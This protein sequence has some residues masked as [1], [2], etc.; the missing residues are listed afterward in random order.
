MAP[1]SQIVVP[2][3]LGLSYV[4]VNTPGEEPPPEKGLVDVAVLDMHH[5]YANLGHASIVESLLN[6]AHDARQRRPGAPAVRVISYDVRRGLAV[7]S[8][9]ARFPLVVG[10]GGPGALDPRENDGV[11]AG[12]QGILENPD[13]E[14]PLFRFFDGVLASTGTA[15]L[16][17][18]H[19]FG[20]LARWGGVARAVLRGPERGGKSAGIVTNVLTDD[21]WA[22][23][24]FGD[25]FAEN[26]GPEVK[27]LDSR[28][29]D[30][31]PTGWGGARPLGFDCDRPGAGRG[32]AVTMFEFARLQGGTVPRVWGVNHHPEIGDVG[33]QRERLERLWENGGVTEAWYRERLTAL[34]AWNASAATEQGLQRTTRWTF[35]KPLRIHLERALFPG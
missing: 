19:S 21:A 28:L 32:E 23:P 17:I 8:F 35:E 16:G 5:G 6:Y 29:F 31:L 10:S 24:F 27:V 20:L 25:Y 14:G 4:R 3:G 18:C 11:S 7:P 15:M 12:S 30:L 13:W 34:A 9:P 2:P 33:L 22:H 26:G 1:G